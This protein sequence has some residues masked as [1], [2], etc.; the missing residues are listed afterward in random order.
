VRVAFLLIGLLVTSPAFAGGALDRF[1]EPHRTKPSPKPQPSSDDDDDDDDDDAY[2][3]SWSSTD[4]DDDD[5]GGGGDSTGGQIALFGLCLIPPFGFSCFMP[6]HRQSV[7]V[8][9]EK[10]GPIVRPPPSEEADR[11][12]VTSEA[13]FTDEDFERVRWVE[14]GAMGFFAANERWVGS[15]ELAFSAWLGPVRLHSRWERFYERV[16]DTGELD[17]LDLFAVHLGSNVVGP[18]VPGLELYLLAG[19]LAMY[20]E[21]WTPAFDVGLE[22]RIY[23]TDPLAIAASTMITVFEQGP[24]LLDMRLEA[25][26]TIDRFELRAGP[27]WLYQGD[28]VQGFWGPTATFAARF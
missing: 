9:D 18:L 20:G 5:D 27:R 23:P 13:R 25:G 15:H 14:L 8:Y 10:H 21:V 11:P 2:D 24:V 16:P 19:M 6:P 22:A 17:N 4:T 1:E 12:A 7:D 28:D 26:I 3:S